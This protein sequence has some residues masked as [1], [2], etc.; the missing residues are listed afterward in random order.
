[1]IV[2]SDASGDAASHDAGRDANEVH[3]IDGSGRSGPKDLRAIQARNA[4]RFGSL[5][6]V[7]GFGL[8][9]PAWLAP[10]N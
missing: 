8:A 2:T 7:S 3:K 6:K 9:R 1:L 4:N 10:P 5:L